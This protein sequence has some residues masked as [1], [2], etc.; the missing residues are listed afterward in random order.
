MRKIKKIVLV[1][2]VAVLCCSCTKTTEEIN[3]A[4]TDSAQGDEI[5]NLQEVI[6]NMKS[7]QTT[8]TSTPTPAPTEEPIQINEDDIVFP[9]HEQV[10]TEE[11]QVEPQGNDLQLVF[12][13]DS[14]FDSNRDGTGIPYL[15]AV[16]CNA[17]VYNLAIGGTTAT[18]KLTQ[19]AENEKWDSTG[20]QGVVKAMQK[21]IPTTIF[22]GTRTKEIL[23][24]SK[25]NLNIHS[26]GIIKTDIIPVRTDLSQGVQMILINPYYTIIKRMGLLLIATVILMIFVVGC[27]AYQIKII[28]RQNKIAQLREDFSY[29][30]IHDMKTPLSSITMCTD[31]LQSGRLD[32]KPEMKEKYFTIV[33]NEAEHLLT[34]TNKILTLSKLENHKLEIDKRNILLEPVIEDLKEKFIAKSAKPIHFT[35]DLEVKKVYTDEEFFKELM[36]NL[37]DNAMKYSKESIEI[38]I[39]SHYD[40]RYTIIK[41]YDNGIGISKKDQRTIFDKFERASATKRTKYGGPAG[42]GLGLNYVYQVIEAHEGKV[43]VNSIEGDFT[44]FTLFIPK[45]M[46]EL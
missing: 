44:E 6:Q 21:K 43:Y 7:E 8:P 30:M 23:D 22:E 37:I 45:I 15:T 36:S 39:S 16:Q 3:Q 29:A 46:E 19:S 12:L 1:I 24:K 4:G 32:G 2:I 35:I 27:I 42:F 13:G 40:D 17:D 14:I 34:L 25:N 31:F 33:K 5:V 11:D 10:I 26:F 9:E 38:K 41:I 18:I 28:A 20:L